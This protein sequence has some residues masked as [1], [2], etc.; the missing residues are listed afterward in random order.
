VTILLVL[1]LLMLGA[2]AVLALGARA[3]TS[4][5]GRRRL[6]RFG[7]LAAGGVVLLILAV[8]A[9]PAIGHLTG[10]F[11]ILPV[12]SGSME[13]EMAR[14]DAAWVRSVPLEDLAVGDVLVFDPPTEEGTE[15]DRTTIH[16]VIEL[17]PAD[18]VAPTDRREGAAYVRTKGDANEVEDPWV[19]AV[20][21]DHVWVHER[22]VPQVGTLL[23]AA[24]SGNARML[25]MFVAAALIF[26]WGVRTMTSQET[27]DEAAQ[28]L[29][30]HAAGQAWLRTAS[31]DTT[32]AA[33]TTIIDV[34]PT[35]TA[36]PP[37]TPRNAARKASKPAAVVMT[38]VAIVLGGAMFAS[39]AS[40]FDS[41]QLTATLDT[42]VVALETGDT[43]LNIP[44][45]NLLPGESAQQLLTMSHVGDIELLGADGSGDIGLQLLVEGDASP[46]VTDT[47]G[48]LQL[49][50]ERC[51]Q[52][53]T[54]DG[55][56]PQGRTTYACAGT[57]DIINI[58]R[59]VLGTVDLPNPPFAAY[60]P[61]GT[62]FVRLTL[63]LPNT[64]PP[65]MAGE[66]TEVAITIVAL[67]REGTNR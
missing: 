14:G 21:D 35:T 67:Q 5:D 18:E 34:P 3:W 4:G 50:V 9:V 49:G 8:A 66:T 36:P 47:S 6:R 53:W 28:R 33:G 57:L 13:P 48:G 59:P 55:L 40:V 61:G 11:R 30:R 17:V 44:V 42:G 27:K 38:A 52:A 62:D 46:L 65:S 2:C 23:T 41:E 32:T 56:D 15:G 37:S 25:G 45:E 51:S 58:A 39:S 12:L 10:D 60:T 1:G 16:R 29:A 19:A 54:V 7:N 20:T 26:T 22:T 24:G 43:T 31:G 64:A 63:S